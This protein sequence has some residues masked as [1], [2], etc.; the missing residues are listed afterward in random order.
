MKRLVAVLLSASLIVSLGACGKRLSDD[1]KT[2]QTS[3]LTLALR[4]GTYAEVVKKDLEAFE[5]QYG[6][7]CHILE[8]SESDLHDMAAGEGPSKQKV[9]LVMADGSWIVELAEKNRLVDLSEYGYSLDTDII[10]A[11]TTISYYKN[12]L[13]VVPYYGNVTVLLY[14]KYLLKSTGYS[15]D[16]LDNMDALYVSCMRAAQS[17]KNGFVY[18][19]DTNNN[20]VVDFLP[21]LLSFGGWVV[22]YDNRPIVNSPEFKEAFNYYLRLIDT[23]A[24]L[25]KEDL[26]ASIDDGESLM[27]IG[28]PGWYMPSE[29]SHGDYG[30]MKG[31]Q[32][33]DDATYN[34]NVYGIWTLGISSDSNNPQM[35]EKLIEYLMD[36]EVQRQSVDVGGVPCRYSSLNNKDILAK[37]P[38]YATICKALE[39][40]QYRPLITQWNDFCE[41]LGAHMRDAIENNKSSSECLDEAQKE[42]EDLLD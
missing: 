41:I 3:N 27:A 20:I 25:P 24:A 42:L 32:S 29:N 38:H 14:N 11:T 2:L 13:Y 15:Y 33:T 36:P 8:L 37:Y 39:S 5:N 6:V 17:G 34:A 30:P 1:K 4:E 26:I 28:W 19:G 12:H 40:G 23:G 9:D 16:K 18:R 21:I 22:D 35:A 31:R 7:S 10:P